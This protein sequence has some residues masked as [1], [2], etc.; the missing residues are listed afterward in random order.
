MKHLAGRRESDEARTLVRKD[1]KGKEVDEAE[2]KKATNIETNGRIH[3]I[4]GG[5]KGGGL[6]SSSWK[7]YIH[8][9]NSVYAK[10]CGE[11][12]NHPD[13][14]FTVRDFEG[15]QPHEDDPI[16]VILRITYYE[17]ERVLLDQ[18]SSADLI[19]GD[20]FEKLGI[21][22]ADFLPYDGAL[23]GFSGER[24]YVRGYVELNTVFGEGNSV[25]SFA[26]KFL[27]VKCTSPYNVL[28]GRPSLNK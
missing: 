17:I 3:S 23:V 8:S 14:T 9:I 25:E 16:V 20:A 24:F 1:D 26:I 7:R 12:G 10:D 11:C 28:I 15:I 13:I 19:Y 6:T 4:F 2:Q 27:V 22:E 18:G 21:T 5:F